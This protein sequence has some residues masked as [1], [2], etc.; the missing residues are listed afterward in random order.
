MRTL[1]RLLSVIFGLS[2]LPWVAQAQVAE[3]KGTLSLD[4]YIYLRVRVPAAGFGIRDRR[5]LLDQRLVYV[6]SYGNTEMPKVHVGSIHGK[7]TIYV[8]DVRFI[9]VY[10]QDARANNTTMDGLARVWA[11]RIYAGIRSNGPGFGRPASAPTAP[12]PEAS[13]IEP[14]GAAPAT[15]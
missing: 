5:V 4:D 15:P 8:G 1:L 2:L 10:P 13:V 14:S 12:L 9:T 7:P 6:L 11:K 3:D